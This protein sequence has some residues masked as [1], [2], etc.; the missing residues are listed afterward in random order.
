MSDENNI[1]DA[2]LIDDEGNVINEVIYEE[3]GVLEGLDN[4]IGNHLQNVLTPPVPPVMIQTCIEAITNY[5]NGDKDRLVELPEGATYKGLTLCS[6]EMVV[7]GH[8]LWNWISVERK[9]I[10]IKNDQT[11]EVIYDG[12]VDDLENLTE[13]LPGEYDATL[14][15]DGERSEANL[16]KV[17]C[18]KCFIEYDRGEML[19]DN[20]ADLDSEVEAGVAFCVMCGV[21]EGNPPT[22]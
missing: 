22:I 21:P 12:F 14:V 4:I 6:S 10:L 15:K 2:I 17:T 8:H 5:N 9:R 20:T 1:D 11:G 13:A 19:F 16:E 18:S 3:Q 7:K